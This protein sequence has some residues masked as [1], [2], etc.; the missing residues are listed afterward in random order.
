MDTLYLM[1][2]LRCIGQLQMQIKVEYTSKPQSKLIM[3]E[4]NTKCTSLQQGFF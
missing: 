2:Q 3:F 4:A 1:K